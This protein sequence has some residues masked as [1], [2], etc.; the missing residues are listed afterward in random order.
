MIKEMTKLKEY[1]E[2]LQQ[3][4]SLVYFYKNGCPNYEIMNPIIDSLKFDIP[5][6]KFKLDIPIAACIEYVYRVPMSST[7]IMIKDGAPCFMFLDIIS[8]SE[9]E[10][11]IEKF[12]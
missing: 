9:L 12:K 10:N 7:I 1:E 5:I 3:K 2:I 4:I 11:T 8:K 6:Y